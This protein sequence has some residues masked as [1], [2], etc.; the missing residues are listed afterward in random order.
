MEYAAKGLYRFLGCCH[1]IRNFGSGISQNVEDKRSGC[2]C[3]L[4]AALLRCGGDSAEHSHG[5]LHGHSRHRRHVCNDGQAFGYLLDG[6]RIVVVYGV[7]FVQSEGK[8]FD[9][10]VIFPRGIRR[11]QK[12][13]GCLLIRVTDELGLYGQFAEPF[14][15][16][17]ITSTGERGNVLEVLVCCNAVLRCSGVRRFTK[18]IHLVLGH[19]GDLAHG[20]KFTVDLFHGGKSFNKRVLHGGNAVAYQLPCRLLGNDTTKAV[21]Q[22][23]GQ[24]RSFLRLGARFLRCG[25]G[26]GL[27]SSQSIGRLRGFLLLCGK[28]VRSLLRFFLRD[29]NLGFC[30]C[31]LCACSSLFG[32]LFRQLDNRL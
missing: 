28:S 18:G 14:C 9:I 11:K 16:F 23:V 5:F 26:F 8:L 13:C 31:L 2:S 25:C 21:S 10:A 24:R 30:R 27:P 6:G 3:R 4:S 22:Q 1:T 12:L 32:L 19:A 29:L 15:S 20:R 17:F 7:G